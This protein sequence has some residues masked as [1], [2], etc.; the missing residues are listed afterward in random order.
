MA[1]MAIKLKLKEFFI[2]EI[3]KNFE[4]YESVCAR[5][6]IGWKSSSKFICTQVSLLAYKGDFI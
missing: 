4:L 3:D 6:A 5:Y 1:R 2:K